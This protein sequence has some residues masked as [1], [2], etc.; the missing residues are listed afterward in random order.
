MQNN[1]P[2]DAIATALLGSFDS[3]KATIADRIRREFTSVVQKYTIGDGQMAQPYGRYNT[4][5]GRIMYTYSTG[6]VDRRGMTYATTIDEA[7]VE[8]NAAQEAQDALLAW[9]KK[10]IGKVG[11]VESAT[12]VCGGHNYTLDIVKGG[13]AIRIDQN[14][15]W[16]TTIRGTWFAQFPARIYVDGKFAPEAKFKAM[17]A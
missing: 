9:H 5:I 14:I 8:A 3:L 15:V 10:I 6:C 4:A 2:T 13:K 16:K 7:K 12:L 17:F 1:L 11:A